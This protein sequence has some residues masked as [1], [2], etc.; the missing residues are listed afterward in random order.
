MKI[1]AS[2]FCYLSTSEVFLSWLSRLDKSLYD[3]LVEHLR[4]GKGCGSNRSKM[5][6]ILRSLQKNGKSDQLVG[7]LRDNYPSILKDDPRQS[8]RDYESL[9]AHGVFEH[10]DP[11]L[12]TFPMR[13]IITEGDT[14]HTSLSKAVLSFCAQQARCDHIFIDDRVYIEYITPEYA[15]V[16]DRIPEK[17]WAIARYKR[18][19]P[20]V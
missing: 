8:K 1:D 14:G 16:I 17:N 4:E 20:G 11:T 15:N 7:F 5:M 19:H 13:L 12:A 18:Q 10:Y 9:N 2:Q 6:H 3:E